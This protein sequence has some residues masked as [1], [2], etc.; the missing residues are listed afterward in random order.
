MEEFC[1]LG[2]VC[3]AEG[4]GRNE[5]GFC[6]FKGSFVGNKLEAVKGSHKEVV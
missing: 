6:F 2:V 5:I 1:F 4:I 3:E